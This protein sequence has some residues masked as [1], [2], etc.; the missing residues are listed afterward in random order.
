MS[1]EAMSPERETGAISRHV[2]A[3]SHFASEFDLPAKS[4]M[5][6]PSSGSPEKKVFRSPV[7][8]V[9]TADGVRP[10]AEVARNWTPRRCDC[11]R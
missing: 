4:I 8:T 10:V 1:H 3:R 9:L 5:L 6:P 2:K 7:L 11:C